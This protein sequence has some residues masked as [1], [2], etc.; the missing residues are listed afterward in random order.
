VLPVCKDINKEAGP[1]KRR[2]RTLVPFSEKPAHPK[3][4]FTYPFSFYFQFPEIRSPRSHSYK[5]ERKRTLETFS[6]KFPTKFHLPVSNS[7]RSESQEGP[8]K[9]FLQKERKKN[10]RN[11]LR[12]APTPQAQFHLPFQFLLP[13][14]EIRS[15]RSRSYKKE[16][17]RTLAMFFLKE[18]PTPPETYLS[19]AGP[20]EIPC[21]KPSK[22]SNF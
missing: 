11:V 13:I 1:K 9:P 18:N 12:E 21:S 2:K 15:P 5:K 6:K 3:P 8:K 14:S 19:R 17:E 4:N 22:T 10:V 7:K 20:R 16:R